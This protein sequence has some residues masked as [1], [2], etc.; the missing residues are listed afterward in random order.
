MAAPNV[1]G[2][3]ELFFICLELRKYLTSP[4]LRKDKTV[5]NFDSQLKATCEAT[6][7]DIRVTLLKSGF[8]AWYVYL[9]AKPDHRDV[10][11]SLPPFQIEALARQ[12]GEVAPHQAVKDQLHHIFH[13]AFRGQARCRAYSRSRPCHP[14]LIT[15]PP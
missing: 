1:V 9:V 15:K 5:N 4:P 12:L 2:A 11:D 3:G 10:M 14:K 8:Q 13:G 6:T 7:R